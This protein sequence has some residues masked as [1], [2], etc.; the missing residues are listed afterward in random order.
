M[1]LE[2]MPTKCQTSDNSLWVASLIMND[3]AQSRME[4]KTYRVL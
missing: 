2:T 4:F 1:P 3:Q